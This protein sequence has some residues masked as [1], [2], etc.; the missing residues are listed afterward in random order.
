MKKKNHRFEIYRYQL[1]PIDRFFQGELFG[2]VKSVDDLIAKKNKIFSEYLRE[3]RIISGKQT[4]MIARFLGVEDEF[5]LYRFAANRSL[6]RETED[7]T[8]EELDNWPSF[9]V[10]IWNHPDEQYIIVEERREAFQ[11]TDTVTNAIVSSLSPKLKNKQLSIYIESLFKEEEFWK[12][13]DRYEGKITD[14][15]FELITP[16]MANISGVLSDDLKALAKASNTARTN[17]Q[18]RA[19]D[20]SALSVEK[21][22]EQIKG[23]VEYS[24]EGGGNISLRAKGVRRRVQTAKTKK[25]FEVDEIQIQGQNYEEITNIFRSMIS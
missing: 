18:I 12:I 22:D 11:H 1:L 15:K 9:L 21:T 7:F 3:L 19:P 8:E 16:N 14:I 20:D 6:V 25:S 24:S 4:Q 10:G 13:V 17:L 23:L 5:F 2:D